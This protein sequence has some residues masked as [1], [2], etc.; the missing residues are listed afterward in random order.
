M[1]QKTAVYCLGGRTWRETSCLQGEGQGEELN[2]EAHQH[3]LQEI[4]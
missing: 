2:P 4:I 3:E 1:Q